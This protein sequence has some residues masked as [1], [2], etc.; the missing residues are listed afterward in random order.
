MGVD[1]L[2]PR[3]WDSSCDKSQQPL[4]VRALGRRVRRGLALEA[5]GRGGFSGGVAA[6]AEMGRKRK[7]T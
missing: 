6:R 5:H 4:I 3:G 7:A 2:V 1:E